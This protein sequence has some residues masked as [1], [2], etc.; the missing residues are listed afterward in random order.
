[1]KLSQNNQS[2]RRSYIELFVVC[3]QYIV[4]INCVIEIKFQPLI[5]LIKKIQALTATCLK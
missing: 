3:V 4:I 1:M 2:K 5:K